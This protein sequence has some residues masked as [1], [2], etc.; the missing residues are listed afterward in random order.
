MKIEKNIPM[1]N[2]GWG[3]W[4]RVLRRMKEGDSVLVKT[5]R[6]ALSI[7]QSAR[8]LKGR[9]ARRRV[10]GGYRVWCVKIVEETE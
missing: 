9:T 5:I 2:N 10:T 8:T 7:S 3:N 4:P 6:D 1:P